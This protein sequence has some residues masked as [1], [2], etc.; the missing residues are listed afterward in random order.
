MCGFFVF[1]MIRR[2]PRS[3]ST[4]TLFPYTTL[5]RAD[6][7]ETVH[8]RLARIDDLFQQRGAV[9]AALAQIGRGESLLQCLA[10]LG[11]AQA[12]HALAGRADEPVAEAGGPPRTVDRRALRAPHPRRSRHTPPEPRRPQGGESR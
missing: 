8:R 10:S 11:E 7:V 6:M 12:A 3:T 9:I 1:V 5:F 4:D 2:P